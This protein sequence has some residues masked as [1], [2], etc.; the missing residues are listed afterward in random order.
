MNSCLVLGFFDGIHIAHRAVIMSSVEFAKNNNSKSTLVTFKNSPAEF[1]GST[2]KYITSRENSL[3]RIK[4]MGVD[5]II[6]LNFKDIANNSAEEYINYLV[7][8]F[9]PISISTGFNHTFG[10]NKSG[11][12]EYLERISQ[13]LGFKYFCIPAQELDGELISS[14]NI[15]KHIKAG[16][17][18]VANKM[19]GYDF[20]LEGNVISGKQIGRTIGFPT[21][22]ILYPEKIVEIPFGVYCATTKI[23]DKNY[24]IVLN[25]GKR[26][27][28]DSASEAMLEAHLIDY[29]GDLYGRKLTLNIIK[30][31]R[32]EKKF[33]NLYELKNQIKKDIEVCLKLS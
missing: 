4:A 22:N 19:L 8:T 31:I 1:F 6:E 33:N 28:V 27:T 12:S 18:E 2:I 29:S 3:K 14:T 13:Y 25:W 24:N 11:N 9:S 23:D 30:K 10:K 16:E 7:K 32:D 5:K 26:P 15:K 20:Q 17:I 21:A